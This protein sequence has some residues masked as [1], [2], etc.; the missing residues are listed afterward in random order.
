[1][2]AVAFQGLAANSGKTLRNAFRTFGGRRSKSRSASSRKVNCSFHGVRARE[3]NYF[4]LPFPQFGCL[5]SATAK[6]LAVPVRSRLS[7][8]VS[9]SGGSQSSK[10]DKRKS[11]QF[12]L[13][14]FR[15]WSNSI[16]ER[17]AGILDI[18]S[19]ALMI[20]S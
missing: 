4:R 8:S 9:V 16:V 10:A 12:L 5:L 15:L 7:S 17:C 11:S 14:G 18:G 3:G 20:A 2:V 1:M 13:A 6:V 19:A